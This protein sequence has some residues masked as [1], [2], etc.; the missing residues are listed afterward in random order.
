V[1]YTDF[2]AD[3]AQRTLQN[4][5]IIQSK[6]DA[7][8]DG[9]YP[10]TQL[11][12][13]LLGLIVLPREQERDLNRFR[14]IPMRELWSEGWP[15]ITESGVEHKSLYDLISALRNAVAHFNVRFMPGTDREL[16]SVRV[17][18]LDS[19]ENGRPVAGS[20]KWVGEITVGDLDDLARR[21][22]K[23]YLKQFSST[24]A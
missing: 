15:R 24:T 20:R 13:S 12:N 9:V 21:I 8:D 1:E 11:W 6:A 18:T 4:L 22:V 14:R 7:G 3:F 17:W 23:L 19:D 16:T 2:I 5:D 10:V